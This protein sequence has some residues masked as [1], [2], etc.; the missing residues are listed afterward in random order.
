MTQEQTQNAIALLRRV[1]VTG[2]EAFVLV[3]IIST[4]EKTLTPVAP[5][6]E[7]GG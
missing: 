6:V 3:D 5:E 7:E 4:L 1:Q 2:N